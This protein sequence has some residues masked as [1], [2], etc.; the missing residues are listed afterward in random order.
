MNGYKICTTVTRSWI[1]V[2]IISKKKIKSIY[3]SKIG[4]IIKIDN[5]LPY[6]VLYNVYLVK[7]WVVS[8]KW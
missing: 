2:T 6:E 5:V 4:I 3:S 7:S 1:L 8:E